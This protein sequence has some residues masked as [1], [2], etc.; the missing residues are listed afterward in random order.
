MPFALQN[1]KVIYDI[2]FSTPSQT[3]VHIGADRKDLGA[4]LGFMAALHTWGR[5]SRTTPIYTAPFRA[6][7]PATA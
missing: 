6:G 4:Q 1:R 5:R 7:L 2:L 3:L